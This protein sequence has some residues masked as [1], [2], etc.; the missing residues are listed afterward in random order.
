MTGEHPV[1]AYVAFALDAS[2]FTDPD[3]LAQHLSTL[4]PP[5]RPRP[6]YLDVRFLDVQPLSAVRTVAEVLAALM[7]DGPTRA[8]Q[9][10]PQ[11]PGG[12]RRP[13]AR[14]SS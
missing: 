5:V 14:V 2:V 8:K 11:P 9:A 6:G 7:Y 10:V 12:L 13:V 1:A 4:F 3:A